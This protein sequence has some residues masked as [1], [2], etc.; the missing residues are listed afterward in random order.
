MRRL[1]LVAV[2]LAALAPSLA[3]A[4]S[5][6]ARVW[7]ADRSPLIVRGSG[8]AAA[9]RVTVTVTGAGRFVRTVTATR[10][11]TIVARWTS[12]PAKAGCAALFIRA[13]GARGT[14]VTLKVAGIEC[15]QPPADAGP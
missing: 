15:P 3:P 14:V 11:G 7:L 9:E 5:L 2:L 1:L 8:F 6:R 13:V 10:S 4:G 12:V